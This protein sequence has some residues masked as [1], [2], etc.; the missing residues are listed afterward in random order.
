[1]NK[2]AVSRDA[3]GGGAT[4]WLFAIALPTAPVQ[5][6][7]RRCQTTRQPRMPHTTNRKA[8]KPSKRVKE[9][10][11]AASTPSPPAVDSRPDLG[12]DAD[13]EPSQA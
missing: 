4:L 3:T 13:W 5:G 7:G 8:G 11:K 9:E 12:D 10:A 1:M 6:R 2:L